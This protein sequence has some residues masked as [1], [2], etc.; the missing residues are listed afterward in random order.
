M[1]K[2]LAAGLSAA[3]LDM[4]VSSDAR[5]WQATHLLAGD[6]IPWTAAAHLCMQSCVID[7]NT[8]TLLW[9]SRSFC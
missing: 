4:Q 3:G 9:D 5:L 1:R 8:V 7:T 2:Q 6:L